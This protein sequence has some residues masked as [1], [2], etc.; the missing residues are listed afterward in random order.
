MH[1]SIGQDRK[2]PFYENKENISNTHT[3]SENGYIINE[4]N[5]DDKLDVLFKKQSELFKKDI[6]DSENKMRNLY[7]VIEPFDGY[8][9]FMLSTALVH[10]AN[11]LQRKQIGNGG[12]RKSQSIMKKS[13]RR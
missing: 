2:D 13:R 11:G 3:L 1:D 6:A 10:E 5:E 9:V 4:K 12:K 7:H 8:R